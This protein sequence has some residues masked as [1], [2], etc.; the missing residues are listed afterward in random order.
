M[1]VHYIS[2]RHRFSNDEYFR[3]SICACRGH[4]RLSYLFAYTADTCML[5]IRAHFWQDIFDSEGGRARISININTSTAHSSCKGWNRNK[6]TFAMLL[7]VRLRF[8]L[9]LVFRL[10]CART[11]RTTNVKDIHKVPNL[12][13]CQHH[14][15]IIHVKFTLGL[16]WNL[17]L[18][19]Y[20]VD[21]YRGV[22]SV[23]LAMY[24]EVG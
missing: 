5:Y 24:R 6:N 3:I 2:V 16:G 21:F 7:I 18:F 9:L 1:K 14:L 11:W 4:D 8:R 12:S 22:L 13:N 17:N 10:G 23:V 15:Y 20:S 19:K